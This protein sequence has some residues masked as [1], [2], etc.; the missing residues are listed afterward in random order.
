MPGKVFNLEILSCTGWLDK[1]HISISVSFRA[2]HCTII[3][4]FVCFFKIK[5]VRK[6]VNLIISDYYLHNQICVYVH[7]VLCLNKI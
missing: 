4:H 5:K 6:R 3:I 7:N 2:K 1:N